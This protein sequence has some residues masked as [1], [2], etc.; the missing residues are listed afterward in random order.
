M[1]PSCAEADKLSERAEVV[2]LSNIC[3]QRMA[4]VKALEDPDRKKHRR[5]G[6]S[7]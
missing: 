2:A 4:A 6:T 7:N 5:K 1:M 3:Q